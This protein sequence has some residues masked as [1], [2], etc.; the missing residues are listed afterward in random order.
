MKDIFVYISDQHS[1]ELGFGRDDLIR[2]PNLKRLAR[3]GT[4]MQNNYTACP[5]CVPARMSMMSGQLVSRIHV[6]NNNTALDSNRPT[7][8]HSLNAVGY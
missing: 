4:V 1:W 2:T 8:A 7:F 3:Q 5:I 6:M